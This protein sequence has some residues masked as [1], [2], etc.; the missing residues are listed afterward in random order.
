MSSATDYG[1]GIYRGQLV[2]FRYQAEARDKPEMTLSAPLTRAP[3]PRAPPEHPPR[4]ERLEMRST[5]HFYKRLSGVKTSRRAYQVVLAFLHNPITDV[6]CL[7]THHCLGCVPLSLT[8]CHSPSSNESGALDIC[9]L[10][11]I[12][13]YLVGRPGHF[14]EQSKSFRVSTTNTEASGPG[15]NP[16]LLS[17]WN[18]EPSGKCGTSIAVR[19]CFPLT[20]NRSAIATTTARTPWTC[21]R[22]APINCMP[23]IWF[24]T[25][26]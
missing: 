13:H 17:S 26:S 14:R 25:C 4:N 19:P 16:C 3:L 22:L 20:P 10:L 11:G 6:E 21:S 15:N 5:R 8:G 1:R 18:H 7:K 2:E 24:R 23:N 9:S 12:P